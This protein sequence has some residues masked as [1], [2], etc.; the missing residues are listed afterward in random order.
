M[1]QPFSSHSETEVPGL[2]CAPVPRFACVSAEDFRERIT[3]ATT[4]LIA[5]GL[6]RD[7]NATGKWTPDYF[8]QHYHDTAITATVDLPAKGCPY[9]LEPKAHVRKMTFAEFVGLMGTANKACYVHQLSVAKLPRLTAD[10]N[11]ETLL[12][13]DSNAC[14]LYFWLG[15]AGTR[16]GLHFDRLDNVNT[17]VFGR[18]LIFLVPPEQAHLLYPFPDNVEKSQVDPDHPQ[19]EMFPRLRDVRALRAVLEPGEILFL[20]KLWW[21]HFRSLEPSIN[22]NCWYGEHIP[23]SAIL[24]VVNAGGPRCWA[25]VAK[26]FISCGLLGRNTGTRLFSEPPTGKFLYLTLAEGVSRRL[27][28]FKR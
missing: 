22:I 5:A 27:S 11:I 7:W 3:G 15:S 23:L 6:T 1:N 21:H 17:Q 13:A 19:W 9:T 24:R 4:P 12:P 2:S 20:P 16:S 26:D 8:S 25:Q 10:T 14:S 28:V 18:K